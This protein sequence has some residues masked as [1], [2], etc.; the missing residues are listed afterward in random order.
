MSERKVVAMDRQIKLSI[1]QIITVIILC[2]LPSCFAFS[3]V[4]ELSLIPFPKKIHLNEGEFALNR[5]LELTV[6]KNWLWLLGPMIRT[7]FQLA[8]L[9]VP[10][11]VPS[12][13]NENRLIL[14]SATKQS[15]INM[16]FKNNA[17]ME[18]YMLSV[19]PETI[20]VSAKGAPGLLY[21]VQTLC[22]LIR[23]NRDSNDNSL[24]CMEIV[25]W[26][27]IKY[28]GISVDLTRRA[29]PRYETL[30]R[31]VDLGAFL[32]LNLFSYYME[33]QFQ[34]KKHPILGPLDGSLTPEELV[35]LVTHAETRHVNVLGSQQSL[36]HMSNVLQHPEYKYLAETP[37]ILRP[38]KEETY[39]FLD[40]LYSEVVPLLPFPFFNVC[41]DEPYELVKK[42]SKE[43]DGKAKVGDMYVRHITRLHEILEK[44]YNKRIMMWGDFIQNY[45]EYIK[46]IPKDTVILSWNYKPA[47]SYEN[48]IVPF[49]D[50]NLAFFVCPSVM[51]WTRILPDFENS[52]TNIQNFVRDG[53]KYGAIGVLNTS[54]NDDPDT[55][56]AQ[57]WY[58]YA[59]GAECSWNASKTSYED[60]NRR[61]GKILF[62]EKNAHFGNAIKLMIEAQKCDFIPAFWRSPRTEWRTEKR[63]FQYINDGEII[64]K[65]PYQT[66]K[67]ARVMLNFLQQSQKEFEKCRQEAVVNRDLLDSFLLGTRRY[68]QICQRAIDILDAADAYD[69]AYD[70]PLN[71]SVALIDK[72]ELLVKKVRDSFKPLKTE[73]RDLY[74][75]ENKVYTL[76][77]LTTRYQKA[78]DKYDEFA[79]RLES[80]KENAAASKPLPKPEEIGFRFKWV[81]SNLGKN[82]SL[83]N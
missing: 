6:D 31:E 23:A 30:T 44:K 27:S 63:F 15:K 7:E 25:D 79:K 55:L 71:L 29:S 73:H 54:W 76:D 77:F 2:I 24:V 32:K 48:Y 75:R 41:C 57:N 65:N 50:A 37:N 51:N 10:R 60:F 42:F 58:G 68:E 64:L 19:Q 34:F 4:S 56:N 20:I 3:N 43:P 52:A 67:Q 8:S 81:N 70:S 33:Y 5:P 12:Q 83:K 28:R 47:K 72:S 62:G 53:A 74:L 82:C 49:A 11:L 80:A 38:L 78:I 61:I 9:P 18:D 16:S 45:P 39:E 13:S 59:W 17:G 22:Q 66:R 26:P 40:D 21:G 35:A 1:F 69:Q 36:A 14:S 46:D